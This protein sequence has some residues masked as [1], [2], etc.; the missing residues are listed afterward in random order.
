LFGYRASEV[1]D[2]LTVVYIVFLNVFLWYF[3]YCYFVAGLNYTT[4]LNQRQIHHLEL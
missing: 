4:T 1:T 2:E 3:Y